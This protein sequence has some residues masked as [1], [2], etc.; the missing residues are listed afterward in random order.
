MSASVVQICNLA[1]L[2][3]GNITID[4]L[5]TATKEERACSVFYPLMRDELL[6]AHPWNFAMARA[7]ISAQ[8][9]DTPAFGFGYAYTL[10][11]DCL[12]AWE[13]YGS[14]AEW[15]V[16]GRELLTDLEEEIYLRYIRQVTE[17]GRFSPAFV[18]CLSTRLGAELAAKLAGDKAMR[19]SLLSELYKVELPAAYRLN[20]IEGN[21][22]KHKDEQSLDNGNY[23]WQSVGR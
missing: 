13:L 10:P 20:A 16:E 17:S 23:S 21:R 22:P 9:A 2:K 14:I 19:E 1:L 12:R 5:G 8:L 6:Y 15:A 7:D 18:N 11:A 3:F 4:N